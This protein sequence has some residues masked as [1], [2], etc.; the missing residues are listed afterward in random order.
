[1]HDVKDTSAAPTESSPSPSLPQQTLDVPHDS[2]ES[3]WY[4][5][6]PWLYDTLVKIQCPKRTQ[7]M[8]FSFH[9]FSEEHLL[10]FLPLCFALLTSLEK[11]LQFS[12]CTR[13]ASD[14]FNKLRYNFTSLL[15]IMIFPSVLGTNTFRATANHKLLSRLY[16]LF[17]LAHHLPRP[18]LL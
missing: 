7:L 14:L 4:D 1:M 17:F 9:Y 8:F 16:L 15:L 5:M 18:V 2:S 12:T 13:H 11:A 3:S 10:Q 6:I